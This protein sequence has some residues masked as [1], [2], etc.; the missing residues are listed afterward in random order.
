M[1]EGIFLKERKLISRFCHSK[2]NLTSIA[3]PEERRKFKNYFCHLRQKLKTFSD[4]ES[5]RVFKF[6]N[7]MT[8]SFVK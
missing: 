7:R 5:V 2:L 4:N 3:F 1:K 8:E 6:K